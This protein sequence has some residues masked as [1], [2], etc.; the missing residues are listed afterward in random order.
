MSSSC[1]HETQTCTAQL[2][3]ETCTA[4]LEYELVLLSHCILVVAGQEVDKVAGQERMELSLARSHQLLSQPAG[5]GNNTVGQQIW[6]PLKLGRGGPRWKIQPSPP[7]TTHTT[8]C[9][10]HLPTLHK[11]T[12]TNTRTQPCTPHPPQ[13]TLHCISHTPTRHK[14]TRHCK[15]HPPK[16]AQKNCYFSLKN[17]HQ[18][19]SAPADGISLPSRQRREA[20]TSRLFGDHQPHAGP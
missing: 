16:E 5:G 1:S 17:T 20:P 18:A 11:H 14:Q 8:H 3:Y 9:N 12:H 6:A 10:P 13:H 4:H 19:P 7:H 2:T 15:P